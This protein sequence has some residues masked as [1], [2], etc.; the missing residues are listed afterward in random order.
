MAIDDDAAFVSG[1]KERQAIGKGA[2]WHPFISGDLANRQFF[3]FTAIDDAWA[4]VSGQSQPF[5][6]RLGGHFGG[7]RRIWEHE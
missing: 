4:L 2:K 5:R 6:H 3:L 1:G 7:E